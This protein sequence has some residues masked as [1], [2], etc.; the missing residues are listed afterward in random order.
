MTG[1]NTGGKNQHGGLKIRMEKEEVRKNMRARRKALKP[2]EREALQ[3]QALKNLLSLQ[4]FWQAEWFFPF[5]SCGTEIDTM[6]LIQAVLAEGRHQL[7]VPRV[8][9]EEMDFVLLHSIQDLVPGA[10]QILEPTGGQIVTAN[11]G[12]MLM[13]GLAFDLQ[14][15]RVG[16]GAGYYDRYLE[17]FDSS[18]L[19]KV[20][21][22]FD[23]QLEDHILAEEHDRRVDAVVTDRRILRFS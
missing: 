14:G 16:Y 1:I 20:A 11:E 9:G 13:P 10:M 6:A 8:R 21:Y 12:L 23:F 4:E 7:A 2:E 17:K 3:K 19:Y 15:N 5:V 18:N 22:A